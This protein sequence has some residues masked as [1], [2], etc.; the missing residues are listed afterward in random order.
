[1]VRIRAQQAAR[2]DS[3][4]EGR[5]RDILSAAARVFRAKGV[6]GARMK[7]IAAELGAAVGNLYYYFRDKQDLL[8]FCQEDGLAGLLELT[9]RV[10]ARRLGPAEGLYLL[11]VGHVVQVNEST[12]GALA[13]LEVAGFA[14]DQRDRLSS[15]R[16]R[17]QEALRSVIEEGRVRGVFRPEIDAKIATLA[18]L[19]ALNWTVR[20]FDAAG[21]K[22]ARQIGGDFAD[23]LV[24][25]LLIEGASFTAPTPLE[26]LP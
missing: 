10:A 19:G 14:P 13:H 23:F 1:M 15:G 24:R 18:L 8:A 12:P 5:K 7:D 3:K 25:G 2:G 9:E 21:A 16:A 4:I 17:Y 20:W 26:E 11:I 22:S 6:T